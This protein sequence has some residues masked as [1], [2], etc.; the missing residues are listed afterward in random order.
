MIFSI[1]SLRNYTI[2]KENFDLQGSIDYRHQRWIFNLLSSKK[3]NSPKRQ[4][5]EF[6]LVHHAWHGNGKRNLKWKFDDN[7]NA[8]WEFNFLILFIYHWFNRN[9]AEVGFWSWIHTR[10]TQ[11]EPRCETNRSLIILPTIHFARLAVNI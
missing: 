9:W 5:F 3:N 7:G 1:F 2:T 4:F 8:M 10:N 11:N 6:S